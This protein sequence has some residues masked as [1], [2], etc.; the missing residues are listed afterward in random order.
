VAFRLADAVGSTGRVAIIE[1]NDRSWFPRCFGHHTP[2][3]TIVPEMLSYP[4]R[5]QAVP[6]APGSRP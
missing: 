4:R 5:R 2:V 1:H 6:H 3:E